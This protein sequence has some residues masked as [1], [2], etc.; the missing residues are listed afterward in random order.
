MWI[1]SLGGY[2]L[3][4]TTALMGRNSIMVCTEAVEDTV[5]RHLNEQIDFLRECDRELQSLIAEIM[6]E[7]LNHLDFARDRVKHNWFTRLM[8]WNI[9]LATGVMIWLSTHGDMSRMKRDLSVA[10]S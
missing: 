7:E 5:H 8:A 1:W 6:V 2:V 4:F 3:G 9:G 10:R